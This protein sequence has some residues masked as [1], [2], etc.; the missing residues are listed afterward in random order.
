MEPLQSR[1]PG[2]FEFQPTLDPS[3]PVYMQ[4]NCPCGC[5]S[6]GILRV[7]R[8][9]DAPHDSNT[10]GWD[11]DEK[12]PTLSPSIRRLIHCKFHGHLQN[13]QWSTCGDGAPLS[14]NV[15]RSTK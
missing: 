9:I 6:P 1:Q 10:W 8:P 13:G 14:S 15:Y 7:L 2:Y 4:Y 5:G 11:G 3:K 12:S